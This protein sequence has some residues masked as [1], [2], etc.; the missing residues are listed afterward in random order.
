ME[1]L[2]SQRDCEYECESVV[3]VVCRGA[4]TGVHEEVEE[5]DG[6]VDAGE[7]DVQD[8]HPDEV[9][10]ELVSEGVGGKRGV[11]V[12]NVDVKVYGYRATGEP[13]AWLTPVV[14]D[15]SYQE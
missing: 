1:R 13:F 7:Y 14:L 10:G 8:H 2:E 9:V 6:E 5:E 15:A 12:H 11:L 3:F 4:D